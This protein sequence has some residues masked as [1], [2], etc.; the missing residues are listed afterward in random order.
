MRQMYVSTPKSAY[1][2]IFVINMVAN[3]FLT[4][5]YN[6]RYYALPLCLVF[7]ILHAY[8][9]EKVFLRDEDRRSLE[10]FYR[11][12]YGWVRLAAAGPLTYLVIFALYLVLHN[13]RFDWFMPSIPI[14]LYLLINDLLK[15]HFKKS[16]IN[17]G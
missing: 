3:L 2:T 17:T 12:K 14:V 6:Y 4:H 16:K 8:A 7:V 15:S 5:V 9:Y 11:T 13:F 10:E 1:V